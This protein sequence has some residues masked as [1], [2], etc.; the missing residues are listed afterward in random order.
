MQ[1]IAKDA[2]SWKFWISSL[3]IKRDLEGLRMLF[4]QT[5]MGNSLNF[6]MSMGQLDCLHR[7]LAK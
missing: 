5:V 3:A 7:I 1:S 2:K 6:E 4:I